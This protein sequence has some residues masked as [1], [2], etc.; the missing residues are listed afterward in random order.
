M[1]GVK[2]FLSGIAAFF[3]C[4]EISFALPLPDLAVNSIDFVPA[5]KEGRNIDLVKISVINQGKAG[6]EKCILVLSCVAVKCNEG[7]KCDEV[8]RLISADIAVPPL[9]QGEEVDLEWKPVSPIE[10]ISGKYSVVAGIDKY[11]AVQESNETNNAGKSVIYI[12]SFS[13]R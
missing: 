8:S 11:N 7:S 12:K 6:A 3:I 5:P 4:F 2:I 9:E 1:R 10:W 13:P